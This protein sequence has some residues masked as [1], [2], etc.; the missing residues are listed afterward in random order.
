MLEQSAKPTPAISWKAA[1]L[2]DALKRTAI[3]LVL[4]SGLAAGADTIA[5]GA[6]LYSQKCSAC[7]GEDARGTSHAPELYRARK[8]RGRST[9]DIRETI[10]SGI[11]TGGMPA[12]SLPAPD[13]DA[14]AAYVHSLNTSASEN[15][16]SGDAQAGRQ[17]F[18]GAGGCDSCHMVSGRG[19]AEVPT[20]PTSDANSRARNCNKR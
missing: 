11:P 1:V 16:V 12:F 5:A 13:L 10:R 7:H 19:K 9:A 2:K 15:P 4:T 8:L 3:A 17:F 6:R 20:Y 18:T 14:L